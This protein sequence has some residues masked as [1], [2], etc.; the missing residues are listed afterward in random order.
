MAG[1]KVPVYA[2]DYFAITSDVGH[3]YSAYLY[4]GTRL[5]L[6]LLKTFIMQDYPQ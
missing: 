3:D 1:S 5:P 2:V 4:D 6:Q